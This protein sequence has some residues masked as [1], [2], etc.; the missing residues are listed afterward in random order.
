MASWTSG[1]MSTSMTYVKYAITIAE[2]ST[3][4]ENNT[5][6]V[7]VSVRFYRTN[8]G[9]QTWGTGTVYCK[10]NG[11]QYS[12][13]VTPSQKIVNGT[14]TSGGIILFSKNLNIAH[15][16][17]GAK[18]LTCSAWIKHDGPTSSEQSYSHALTA[19]PRASGL[20]VGNGTLGTAQTITA[21]RKSSSFT[22]TLTWVS[23]SYSGTICTK[24]SSTSWSFTPE[25]KLAN[26]APNG[27]SVYCE[28]TLTTYN[29]STSIGS[30]KKAVW[31]SIPASV[32]P[33]CSLT[34]SDLKGYASTYGGYIQG[35]SVLHVV[36]NATPAYSS[37]IKT[38]STWANNSGYNSQTFNTSIL[39]N[40]GSNTISTTVTD[41]RGR[42]GTA[43]SSITV[44]PYS[45]PNGELSVKRGDVDETTG[46]FTENDQ[47]EHAKV[48][49]WYSIT[50]LS[51]K[52]TKSVSL[53][54]RPS[55]GTGWTTINLNYELLSSQPEDWSTNYS[56]YYTYDATNKTYSSVSGDTAPEWTTLTY[57]SLA[58]YERANIS[59]LFD[60]DTGSSYE[61][62]LVIEDS[63]ASTI[64]RTNLSTGYCLFHVPASGK[65]ITFG[66]VAEEDGFNVFMDAHFANGITEDIAELY[67]GDCNE[68]LVSGT[69]Y[70]GD[71]GTNRPGNALNGWLMVKAYGDAAYC[72]QSYVTYQGDRY[73]RMRDNGTWGIWIHEDSY[74]PASKILYN[75]GEGGI[76]MHATQTAM[77]SEPVSAQKNG[78]VMCWSQFKDNQAINTDFVYSFIPKFHVASYAGCGVECPL[79]SVH[80]GGKIG[81]KIV[82]VHDTK[83]TGNDQNATTRGSLENG[84]WVLRA[85]M[86]V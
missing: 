1:A 51:N 7:T 32:K 39:N 77:L 12:A 74:K 49:I 20:S 4:V 73:Y 60:A 76:Y 29:G 54:Y 13:S 69:Y 47:G 65:G 40:S 81:S 68:L 43:S 86:G 33:A 80:D 72:Y 23:G 70:I 38:Y 45:K 8:T 41:S 48:T 3:S 59:V 85:I 84:R 56:N 25:L 46:E 53:Q 36:V 52:N 15:D 5:S 62:R 26:G 58:P 16:S 67:Q 71:E 64:P 24:S 66:A 78:I 31:L 79:S 10:I 19:I 61:V 30:A 18:T 11:T 17:N 75:L 14:T 9:Y 28:F 50:S 6:N 34:L 83:V 82:Y 2:N 63:F 44:I 42:T 22:H 35:Q 27:T 55:S 21:D 57:Y 37:S